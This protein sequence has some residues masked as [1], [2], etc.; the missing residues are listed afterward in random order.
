MQRFRNFAPPEET[1]ARDVARFVFELDEQPPHPLVALSLISARFPNISLDT[2]LVGFVFRKLLLA[3][4]RA[5][6]Q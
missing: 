4:D 1:K 2:A 5:V 3:K 6:L